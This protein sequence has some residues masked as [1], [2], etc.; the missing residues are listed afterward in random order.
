LCSC[1]SW[2]HSETAL[3]ALILGERAVIR[4]PQASISVETNLQPLRVTR[5]IPN[6]MVGK[7]SLP[8]FLLLPKLDPEPTRVT[9]LNE[10]H[11]AF[12]GNVFRRCQQ[13]M[14]VLGH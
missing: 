9:A 6:P 10:L 11:G 4:R 8:N 14:Q 12:E 7:T 2:G 1:R 3:S 5:P 13:Q